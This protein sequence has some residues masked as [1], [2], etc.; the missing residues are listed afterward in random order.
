MSKYLKVRHEVVGAN[1]SDDEGKWTVQIKNL[2]TNT[3]FSDTCDFLTVSTGILN[4]WQWPD[5]KGL[6]NFTGKLMHTADYD[7]SYDIDGKEVAV[8]GG[9]SSAIQVVPNIQPKVK[10]ID[11]YMRSK[12]WIASGGFAGEEAFKRNPDGGNCKYLCISQSQQ[13]TC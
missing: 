1:W 11:H 10:K 9:G 2:A 6:H 4:S 5:I 7:A 13:Q 3:V 8:I 12:M